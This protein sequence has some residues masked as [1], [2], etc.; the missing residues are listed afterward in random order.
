LTLD[1]LGGNEGF[2]RHSPTRIS[3]VAGKFFVSERRE[4]VV[5]SIELDVPSDAPSLA[6]SSAI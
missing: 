2:M 6:T 3:R 1:L 5:A 4:M